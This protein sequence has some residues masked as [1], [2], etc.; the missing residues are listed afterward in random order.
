MPNTPSIPTLEEYLSYQKE[1]I[2]IKDNWYMVNSKIINLIDNSKIDYIWEY[3]G[4]TK[5]WYL[6]N[7]I[8][9]SN[10]YKKIEKIDYEKSYWVKVNDNFKINYLENIILGNNPI[11][12]EEPPQIGQ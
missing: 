7:N 11:K 3:N 1:L 5:E 9:E 8:N 6:K 2:F 10:Q 4:N 12:L